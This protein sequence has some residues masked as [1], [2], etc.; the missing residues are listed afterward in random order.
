MSIQNQ[1]LP[2]K[3]LNVAAYLLW[4]GFQLLAVRFEGKQAYFIFPDDEKLRSHMECYDA[5]KASVDLPRYEFIRNRLLD[6]V[7]GGKS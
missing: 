4:A 5:G 7:K 2:V 3:S 6:K 1:E